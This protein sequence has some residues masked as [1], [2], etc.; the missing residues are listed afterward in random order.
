MFQSC[1]ALHIPQGEQRPLVTG[2]SEW[3]AN[4]MKIN[5]KRKGGQ[6]EKGCSENYF[7]NYVTFTLQSHT[8]E[9]MHSK[10]HLG[11][12]LRDTKVPGSFYRLKFGSCWSLRVSAISLLL[13]IPS[14]AS[15]APG[16]KAFLCPPLL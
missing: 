12:R 6:D 2:G 3:T 7:H 15:G 4:S 14:K 5:K 16:H 11:K 8:R 13:L 1:T 10:K 9:Q